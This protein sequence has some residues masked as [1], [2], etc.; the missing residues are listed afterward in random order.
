MYARVPSLLCWKVHSN[1]NRFTRIIGFITW[2]NIMADKFLS[3]S[4]DFNQHIEI[5]NAMWITSIPHFNS[6]TNMI[7][8]FFSGENTRSTLNDHSTQLVQ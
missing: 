3:D 8:I 6:T 2:L 5:Y 4:K 7:P 1:Y